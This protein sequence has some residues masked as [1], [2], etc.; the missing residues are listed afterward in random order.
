MSDNPSQKV[1]KSNHNTC[2]RKEKELRC[3]L[4]II[5]EVKTLWKDDLERT[6]LKGRINGKRDRSC[7]K[8]TFLQSLQ[9]MGDERKEKHDTEREDWRFMILDVCDRLDSSRGRSR[10]LNDF[11]TSKMMFGCFLSYKAKDRYHSK[12]LD[13][14]TLTRQ[15]IVIISKGYLDVF[16]YKAKNR[17]HH[18]GPINAFGNVWI[19]LKMICIIPYTPLYH[20]VYFVEETVTIKQ[21]VEVRMI[22]HIPH[23]STKIST[24]VKMF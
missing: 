19:M 16:S 7:Q 15:R 23:A 4:H 14:F 9:W 12:T 3:K 6:M 1:I 11:G 20:H 2:F 22:S 5:L 21:T 8:L 18:L 17:Y 13:V 10:R 24:Q